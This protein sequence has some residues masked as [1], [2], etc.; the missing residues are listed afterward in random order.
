MLSGSVHPQDIPQYD[1]GPHYDMDFIHNPAG[2][3]YLWY[4]SDIIYAHRPST[5]HDFSDW[6]TSSMK[7]HSYSEGGLTT[8]FSG[9]HPECRAGDG[10]GAFDHRHGR[11]GQQ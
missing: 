3:S 1:R 4:Q 6:Q 8:V 2:A 9:K 10:P 7:R 11:T 5:G